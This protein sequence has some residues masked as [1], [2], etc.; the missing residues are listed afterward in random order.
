[1]KA[2]RYNL[3]TLPILYLIFYSIS[4][5]SYT[6]FLFL[7]EN[8]LL[9]IGMYSLITSIM[10]YTPHYKKLENI[11]FQ[12]DTKYEEV[13]SISSIKEVFNKYPLG[14]ILSIVSSI[15]WQVITYKFLIYYGIQGAF[16][17]LMI[18][19]LSRLIEPILNVYLFGDKIG[20]H[21][22]YWL[23]LIVSIVG[24]VLIQVSSTK[25]GGINTISFEYYLLSVINLVFLVMSATIKRF[26]TG[27][28]GVTPTPVRKKFLY[29]SYNPNYYLSVRKRGIIVETFTFLILVPLGLYLGNSKFEIQTIHIVS[30][31]WIGVLGGVSYNL[32]LRIKNIISTTKT[33]ALDSFRP[34]VLFLVYPAIS[35][36]F[37]LGDYNINVS[38]L[39]SCGLLLCLL[40]GL[41]SMFMGNPQRNEATIKI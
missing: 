8:P 18:T 10:L 9:F 22:Y 15:G 11:L 17:A 4:G 37:S 26:I 6:V 28:A 16:L 39:I 14:I 20:N 35:M 31:L 2:N 24:V 7:K 13:I 19:S 38:Y 36:I 33:T 32:A 41:M 25:N 3:I 30:L 21:F 23:G 5:C 40:G 1:M 27:K 34:L 12:E 29:I